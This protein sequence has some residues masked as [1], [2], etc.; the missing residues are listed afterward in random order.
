MATTNEAAMEKGWRLTIKTTDG[1]SSEVMLPPIPGKSPLHADIQEIDV[2][3][4]PA[5]HYHLGLHYCYIN[6]K[7]LQLA[8][9]KVT[10]RVT[11]YL[12]TQHTLTAMFSLVIIAVMALTL[13]KHQTTQ[14][15]AGAWP[16]DA[17]LTPTLVMLAMAIITCT[18]D[19]VM[20][21]VQCLTGDRA[22]RAKLLAS[23]IRT[24]G[25][26]LQALSSAAGAGFLKYAENNSNGNDLWSWTC[27]NAADQMA[28]V[29]ASGTLCASN[30]NLPFIIVA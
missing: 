15:V 1:T 4:P 12:I 28:S 10:R 29:N 26:I 5:L 30:V 21:I 14:M 24:V 8:P 3:P 13:Q 2:S 22:E 9:P 18:A 23:R 19:I 6:K 20:V 11:A 7:E 25:G 17:Y 27:S 16:Q